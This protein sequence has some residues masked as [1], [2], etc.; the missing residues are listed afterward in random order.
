M[1]NPHQI[2]AVPAA[3]TTLPISDR[4]NSE[5]DHADRDQEGR[6]KHHRDAQYPAPGA[7]SREAILGP[8]SGTAAD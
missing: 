7:S 6:E 5:L 3:P 8:R 4:L 1:Q 2:V